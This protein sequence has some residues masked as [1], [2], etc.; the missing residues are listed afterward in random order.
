MANTKIIFICGGVSSSLGKGV[1]TSSLGLLLEAH[2][3]KISIIKL[4]GYL[5]F[6]ASLLAP[7]SHG[8]V[9]V[10]DDGFECDLDFGTYY[11]FTDSPLN[12]NHSITNGQ[13]FS[14]IIEKERK[15]EYLGECIQFIP[16]VT[17]ELKRRIYQIE[18]KE[19]PEYLLVEI[20]GT[21]GDYESN[22]FF[23]ATRQIIHERGIDNTLLIMLGLIPTVGNHELKTKPI[24]NAAKDL[25]SLGLLPNVIV[26]R[27]PEIINNS[28]EEKLRL[29]TNASY[30]FTSPNVLSIYE[31][32]KMLYKQGIMNIF[33]KIN[34]SFKSIE[35]IE[36]SPFHEK[37]LNFS[38]TNS[39]KKSINIG[40]IGKYTDV[41]DSYKSIEESLTHAGVENECSI[42]LHLINGEMLESGGDIVHSVLKEMNG[43][44][45]PGGFGSRG[46]EGKLIA[47]KYA[48]EHQVPFF[49][50]CL[51]MQLMVI[52]WARYFLQFSNPT[53]EEF[54]ECLNSP[55]ERQFVI[56]LMEEQKKVKGLGGTLRLG[57]QECLVKPNTLLDEAY[58][59]NQSKPKIISERHRHRYEFNN[60]YKEQFEKSGLILSGENTELGLVEA[61]EWRKDIGFGIAC[62]WHPE[63]TSK[64][65]QPAPLFNLFVKEAMKKEINAFGGVFEHYTS[66]N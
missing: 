37:W 51:G 24:Q 14:T 42:D 49:G 21:I 2:K 13:I 6:D 31:L 11:R 12:K 48:R 38:R 62:Q 35:E 7:Q 27:A 52:D 33:Q 61:V 63:F 40:V 53:S 29:F 8:E 59:D 50:I 9:Y 1:F 45:V 22:L 66:T 34:R 10:L 32:P 65:F 5:N 64:L 41:F 44:L 56:S 17:N 4:D 46:I 25:Q 15:G 55:I 20:G 16:H 19:K 26:C 39:N 3:A 30:I 28:I 18:E 58:K 57:L 54:V 60:I 36:L 47:I 43:I 23:E